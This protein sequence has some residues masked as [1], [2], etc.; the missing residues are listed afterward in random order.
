[1]ATL[2]SKHK[3]FIVKQLACFEMPSDVI[4]MFNE[5]FGLELNASQV[6]FYNPENRQ[7][8]RLAE[9]WRH[10][11]YS[12][13]EKFIEEVIDIPIAHKSYRLN[14]LQKTLELAWKRGNT[15]E[16]RATI[17]QAAKECGGM[18]DAIKAK[19]EEGE[20]GTQINFFQR[21][22]NKIIQLNQKNNG[23]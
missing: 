23:S 17:E 16:V 9:K 3:T 12:T 5:E 20:G 13:R 2:Q 11:F 22:E 21:I 15:V 10:L 6:A 19:L 14:F 1:M 18:Y 8:D 7:A 4:K